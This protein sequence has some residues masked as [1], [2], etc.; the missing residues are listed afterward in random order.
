M[1]EART[2]TPQSKAKTLNWINESQGGLTDLDVEKI[3]EALNLQA[4]DIAAAWGQPRNTHLVAPDASSVA[5]R[6]VKAYFLPNADVANALGYHDVDPQGDP[7][8]RV[9]VGT[10]LQNGGSKLS[11]SVSV[12]VCASHEAAEE[13]ADPQCTLY[14]KPESNG[15][16]VAI[17][18]ADPVENN[19][20]KVQ[21]SDGT[22]VDVSDFVFPSFFDP[23]GS[24]P[25]DQLKL[26][27]SPFQ[28]LSGGYEIVR[29]PNGQVNQVFGRHFAAWRR[30]MTQPPGAQASRTYRRLHPSG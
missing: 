2:T 28:I 5:A 21:T 27:G 15:N 13:A 6:A 22:D 8:I 7:Y 4:P 25:Y 23:S 9:F 30:Q 3:V 19:S 16:E 1:S 20:Y 17:E 10:I 18:V 29:S 12:S 14:S 24:P 11:G 26:V